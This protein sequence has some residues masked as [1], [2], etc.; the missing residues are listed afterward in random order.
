MPQRITIT[1]EQLVLLLRAYENMR[2][3][4]ELGKGKTTCSDVARIMFPFLLK[5]FG[6]RE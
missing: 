4:M 5:Q 1:Q 3:L 6:E 2:K